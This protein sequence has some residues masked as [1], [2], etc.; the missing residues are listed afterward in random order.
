M[1]VWKMS[2]SKLFTVSVL[3]LILE[4]SNVFKNDTEDEKDE[5]EDKGERDHVMMYD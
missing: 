1:S 3:F 4:N 5:E 2:Y